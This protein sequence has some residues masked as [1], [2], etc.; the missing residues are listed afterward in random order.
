MHYRRGYPFSPTVPLEGVQREASSR[1]EARQ[2]MS[3]LKL[4]V[5][6]NLEASTHDSDPSTMFYVGRSC[7]IA[8]K[9]LKSAAFSALK[10]TMSQESE[11]GVY[12]QS[13]WKIF[14]F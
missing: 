7:K 10:P 11:E 12:G 3:M 2:L 8:P 13:I 5:L 4:P 1:K 9:H 14:A 6:N